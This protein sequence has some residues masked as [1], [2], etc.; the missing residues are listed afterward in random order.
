MAYRV[1]TV[2]KEPFSELADHGVFDVGVVGGG[3]IGLMAAL[4]FAKRGLRVIL[5]EKEQDFGLEVSSAHSGVIHVLQPPFHS[6]KSRLARKGNRMYDRLCADLGVP[7][8][9]VPALL[10][11]QSWSQ[12]ASLVAGYLYLRLVLHGEYRISLLFR[13]SLRALEP[14]LSTD[15]VAGIAVYGYGIVDGQALVYRLVSALSERGVVLKPSCGVTGSRVCKQSVSVSTNCGTYACSFVVNAAGLSAD[16]V[17]KCLGDDLGRLSRGAGVT[18]EV[19]GL[20]TKCIITRFS[21]RGSSRTKGGGI[22]PTLRGTVLIGP[23]FWEAAENETPRPQDSKVQELVDRFSPLLFLTAPISVKGV[24]V[25]VR[26]LS[27]TGDF[28]V[29]A[30]KRGR[31][32]HLLGMESPGLTA[33]PALA[34]IIADYVCA[35]RTG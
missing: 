12:V 13:K 30:T 25:G 32:V 1:L 10:V 11:V 2:D 35:K 20:S 24:K 26:P 8:L 34:Q 28:V 9:R 29:M 21:L 31:V 6:K 19:E 7:L 33:A 23:S 18:L 27:P 16:K 15:V 5:F 3:V 4:E 14:A 22:I 17:A